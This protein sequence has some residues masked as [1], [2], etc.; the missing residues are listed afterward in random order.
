MR[1]TKKLRETVMRVSS[2]HLK[3]LTSASRTRL[4]PSATPATNSASDE[5]RVSGLQTGIPLEKT[6][7]T[8]LGTKAM[9]WCFGF[10]LCT[11]Y[12][13]NDSSRFSRRRLGSGVLLP[14][15]VTAQRPRAVRSPPIALPLGCG[16]WALDVGRAS[17]SSFDRFHFQCFFFLLF[18]YTTTAADKRTCVQQRTPTIS[19]ISEDSIGSHDTGVE[20]RVW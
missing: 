2:A 19:Y 17:S 5:Q 20:N 4:N 8:F 18:F 7:T 3:H 10:F 12:S 15:R 14:K 16:R 9:V 1:K 11:T 13:S 6:R